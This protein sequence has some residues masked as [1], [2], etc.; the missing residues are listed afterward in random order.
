MCVCVCVCV[1]V[2]VCVSHDK[3]V[4][5][6]AMRSLDDSNFGGILHKSG[7]FAADGLSSTHTGHTLRPAMQ[8]PSA[9]G[10]AFVTGSYPFPTKS[11]N[12]FAPLYFTCQHHLSPH[13][14]GSLQLAV[15][16]DHQWL[17]RSLWSTLCVLTAISTA[18]VPSSHSP[19][20]C[21]VWAW[22]AHPFDSLSASETGPRQ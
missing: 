7:M 22:P 15:G 1:T 2:C 5:M 8:L 9:A 17:R 12:L 20:G 18:K 19:Q 14:L 3:D 11:S 16:P 4:G 6:E 13:P 21:L 10:A